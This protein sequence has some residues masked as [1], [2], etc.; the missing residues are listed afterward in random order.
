MLRGANELFE[1]NL[2]LDALARLAITLGSDVPFLVRGGSAIVEGL[3]DQLEHMDRVPELHA[4]LAFPDTACPTGPVYGRFDALR[5]NA[6][7]QSARVRALI[8]SA[9]IA[10]D[11]PFNDLA[12]PACAVAPALADLIE[13]IEAVAQRRVHVSGSGSTLFFICSGRL[14][15][16]LLATEVQRRVALPTAAISAR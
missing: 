13:E 3:G 16:D 7:L 11:A 4:V 12:E 6:A 2:S 15:A 14:E 9:S 8:A 1:L 5:P 10:H